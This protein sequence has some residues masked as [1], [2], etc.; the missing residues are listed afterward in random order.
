M[1]IPPPQQHARLPS[2]V[3][4]KVSNH[5]AW[6][7]RIW[8]ITEQ[9]VI[10]YCASARTIGARARARFGQKTLGQVECD[11]Y[12]LRDIAV[13]GA[14]LCRLRDAGRLVEPPHLGDTRLDGDLDGALLR[15]TDR[16]IPV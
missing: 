2:E 6:S 8:I 16:R 3:E 15:A 10:G 14:S 4:R 11:L 12:P 7:A 9:R 13:I 1:A 5:M